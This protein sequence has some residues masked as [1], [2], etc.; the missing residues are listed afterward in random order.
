MLGE[1]HAALVPTYL[2]GC[3][4]AEVAEL[5]QRRL[6][7]VAANV[8]ADPPAAEPGPCEEACTWSALPEVGDVQPAAALQGCAAATV[9]ALLPHDDAARVLQR[10]GMAAAD[11]TA[12]GQPQQRS[13]A[14]PSASEPSTELQSSQPA[15]TES[16]DECMDEVASPAKQQPARL[17]SSPAAD[18]PMAD[19]P[20]PAAAAAG[21][22]ADPYTAAPML[23]AEE[24]RPAQVKAES[25][26]SIAGAGLGS[27]PPADVTE[28][29]VDAPESGAANPSAAMTSP[30]PAEGAS[31]GP[32][33]DAMDGAHL[34]VQLAVSHQDDTVNITS[35]SPRCVSPAAVLEHA[36]A[37]GTVCTDS[38]SLGRSAAAAFAAVSQHIHEYDGACED[39]GAQSSRQSTLLC[40]IR[41]AIIALLAL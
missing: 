9:A 32:G 15:A 20:G 22:T 27:G 1:Q 36:L 24:H 7:A 3:P 14:S 23:P 18:G 10:P 26:D 16:A 5:I 37:E 11:T 8:T 39:V 19:V 38:P 28:A 2:L 34:P 35:A 21:S 29:A 17:T 12:D 33:L 6:E 40:C 31:Q 30:E 25:P 4:V 13:A 41:K